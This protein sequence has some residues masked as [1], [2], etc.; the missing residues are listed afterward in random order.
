[1]E[2]PGNK[3]VPMGGNN[4][5]TLMQINDEAITAVEEQERAMAAQLATYESMIRANKNASPRLD[6]GV[7]TA[8]R[9][10]HAVRLLDDLATNNTDAARIA[11]RNFVKFL[12]NQERF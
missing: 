1:M 10:A 11:A 3:M 5:E 6:Y 9:L 2:I 7:L 12:N 4:L 8:G